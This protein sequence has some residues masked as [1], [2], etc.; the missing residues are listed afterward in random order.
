MMELLET[1]L[2]MENTD[3]SLGKSLKKLGFDESDNFHMAKIITSLMR[4]AEDGDLRAIE[5]IAKLLYGNAQ[6]VNLNI[7][8]SV[9]MANRVQIYL[10]ERDE[11]P[12]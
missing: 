11:E 6:D 8:G 5:M 3:P 10:P 4:K 7:E 9:E 12:E 2:T 1:L